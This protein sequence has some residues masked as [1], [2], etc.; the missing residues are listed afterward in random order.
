MEESSE[1]KAAVIREAATDLFW[2]YGYHGTSVRQISKAAGIP[3]ANVYHYFP[4]KIELLYDIV[5][6]A[7]DHLAEMTEKATNEAAADAVSQFKAVIDAHVRFHARYVREG[8]VG[9]SE[10]RSL[11]EPYYGRYVSKR[12]EQQARFM[13]VIQQGIDEKVFAV[14]Y[15]HETVLAL[16]T[17]C[18]QLTLWY[19]PGGELSEDEIV[20]RFIYFSLKMVG[21]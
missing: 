21:A 13:R 1:A 6:R 4:S 2:K 12:D 15:P 18:T 5:G 8:V 14:P 16:I 7:T 3:V 20:E 10:L 19:R 9:N 11:P 17:M